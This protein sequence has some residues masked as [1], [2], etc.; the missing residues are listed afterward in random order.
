MNVVKRDGSIQDFRF[1]KIVD[2]VTKAFN[3]T[4]IEVPD[5]FISQL[6]DSVLKTMQQNLDKGITTP[7]EQI[8]DIIQR[9]L[10]KR[11]KYEVVDAFITVR[12]DRERK[13]M[14]KTDLIKQIQEKLSGCN[15]QNQNANLDEASF[16]GR[17]G[18][19]AGVVAK[20]IALKHVSKTTKKNHEG[21]VVY[22]H[23]RRIVA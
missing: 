16:G 8:Q 11:N 1:Q 5:K 17:L 9:E 14:E 22:I 12:R 3:A 2:A 23:K 4:S 10:I 18:E 21:N 7:I 20:E 6:R 15:V 13:R 19:T